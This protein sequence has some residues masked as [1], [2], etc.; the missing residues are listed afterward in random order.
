MSIDPDIQRLLAPLLAR[1]DPVILAAIV[2]HLGTIYTPSCPLNAWQWC[3][4]NILIPPLE[5]PKRHGPYDSSLAPHVRRL[6]EFVAHP[7]DRVF[8]ARK[9]SQI[10]FTLA[11]LLIICFL[12]AT[13]PRHVLFAMDSAVEAR[14]ISARL[15]RLILYNYSLSKITT[16]DGEEDLQNLLLKLRAMNVWFVGAGAAGGFA[17]KAAGLV[18]LDE[19]DLYEINTKKGHETFHRALERIKDDPQGKFIAGG[20][21]EAYDYPTNKNFLLGTR[22]EIFLPCPHCGHYQ[23]IHFERLKY[24]HCKDLAGAWDFSAVVNETYLECE[25]SLCRGRIRDEDKPVMLRNYKCV[26]MNRGQDDDKPIPDWVSLWVNDLTSIQPQHRWGRIALQ[27]ITSLGSPAALRTFFL[28]VLARPPME[29]KSEVSKADQAKL[30][31]G[32]DHGCMPKRPA[33]NPDTGEAA[34]IL[35]ADNQGN[36]EKKWVKLGLTSTGEAFVIDYGQTLAFQD[37]TVEADEPVWLGLRAPA[38]SDVEAA[39]AEAVATARPY[40]DVLRERF[41]GREFFTASSGLIDEGHDTFTVRDFCHST[42]PSPE[43]PPRFFPCKGIAKVNATEMVME[44]PD[45]FRTAKDGGEIITVYHFSDDDL[46]RELYIGRIGGFDAMK[47]A[48]A[49]DGAT[50][51]TNKG[52]PRLWFPAYAEEWFLQELRQEKRALVKHKGKMVWM[53][54]APKGAN[55]YGDALKMCFAAWHILRPCFPGTESPLSSLSEA[56]TEEAVT[57]AH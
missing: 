15:K 54:E 9:S 6:M 35:C 29:Q 21:P 32:Y 24:A 7:T 53:W 56:D 39:K 49:S 17:N 2:A 26:A 10:G 30:N 52:V 41:P 47:G 42:K 27:F 25:N 11:Y 46:K 4:A 31:G 1:S 44:I 50:W 34:I 48:P 36:G 51:K 13:S 16:E 22:E 8:V 5:S 18:Y 12:A 45:K 28:G 40:F 19:L 55:D 37:L 33:I 38:E 14:N 20:K 57:A 43:L 23:P 3:E